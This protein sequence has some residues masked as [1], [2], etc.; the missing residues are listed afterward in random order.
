MQHA[1][2]SYKKYA[3]GYNEL[4]PR[5]QRPNIRSIFGASK[6][7]ATIID[8]MDTLYI[9]GLKA[10]F[11]EGKNWI[12]KNFNLDDVD[13]HISV[14]ETNIRFI[15]GFLSLYAMTGDPLFKNKAKYVADKL[16]PAFNTPTGIPYPNI[17]F[18]NGIPHGTSSVLAE[19]GSLYLE[20]AYLSEIT[21]EFIYKNVVDR[22]YR[23]LGEVH[24][25]KNLFPTKI[26]PV[27]GK[28][29]YSQ[30]SIGALGD[31]FYEYLLK[32]WIQSGYKDNEMREMFVNSMSSVI[33]RLVRKTKSGYTYISSLTKSRLNNVMEHLTCYTGGLFALAANVSI[34]KR[35]TNKY[36]NLSYEITRTC[37]ESYNQTRTGLGPESFFIS[38]N[39]KLDASARFYLLR[40]ETVESYFYLWRFTHDQRYRDWG[41]EIVEALEKHCRTPSGYAG[42]TDVNSFLVLSDDIQQSYF[43]AETLKYLYLLFS[44]DTLLPLNTWVFNTEAHPLPIMKKHHLKCIR[45][46]IFT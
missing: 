43:L 21:V 31:S 22:I 45:Q 39:G 15:G 16:L 9:M 42:V 32:I 13:Q 46:S 35:M 1:W 26:N 5:I 3:W 18:N 12:E 11:D 27:T 23:T 17:N 2:N 6:T 25:K 41:W 8:A 19:F 24:D 36:Q 20:F 7:G 10:E 44:S 40:P 34:N 30:C 28:W 4:C 38:Q 37:H 29:D 33:D 14:F